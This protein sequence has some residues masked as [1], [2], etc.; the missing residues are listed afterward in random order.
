MQVCPPC[1]P[2]FKLSDQVSVYERLTVVLVTSPAPSNPSLVLLKTVISSFSHLRDLSNCRV[3]IYFDGYTIHAEANTKSGRVTET[4]AASYEQY[5]INAQLEFSSQSS[6][7]QLVKSDKHL[8]FAM[9]VK[10]GLELCKTEFA[11]IVQHDRSFMAP[12]DSLPAVLACM[13]TFTHIRYVGFPTVNSVTHE[14]VIRNYG[15]QGLVA[16]D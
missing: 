12:F 7:Y 13:D 6:Q 16:S 2:I 3:I 9:C 14:S 5:Y 11:L 4:M 8:G 15:L 1:T 10:A